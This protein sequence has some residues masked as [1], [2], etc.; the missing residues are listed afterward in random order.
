MVCCIVVPGTTARGFTCIPGS[1]AS[2]YS[3]RVVFCRD[4]N[5]ADRQE[6]RA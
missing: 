5:L 4:T 3:F 1:D 6:A 2:D